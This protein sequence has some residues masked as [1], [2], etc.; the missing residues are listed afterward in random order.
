[1]ISSKTHLAFLLCR[2]SSSSLLLF[3][4]ANVNT[5][6]L[7]VP[8]LEWGSINLNYGTLNERLGADEL[9]V[10]GIVDHI[11]DT[12][13]AGDGLATPGVV[14]RVKPERPPLD[15]SSSHA[16]P[17]HCLVAGQLRV[18]RLTTQLIPIHRIGLRRR[19]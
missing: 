2:S 18:R 15:V 12:G 11:E 13:L 9:V 7:E 1:M 10:R 5:I 14:A 19:I 16:H 8:L 3:L 4:A 17:S 6:V